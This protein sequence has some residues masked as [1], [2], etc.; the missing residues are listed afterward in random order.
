M[1]TRSLNKMPAIGVKNTSKKRSFACI[2][3]FV[4]VSSPKFPANVSHDDEEASTHFSV[5]IASGPE[6]VFKAASAEYGNP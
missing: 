2:V 1:L 4:A 6:L 5:V 3:Q